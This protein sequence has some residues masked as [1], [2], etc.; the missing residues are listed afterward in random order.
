MVS[1]EQ[2][3]HDKAGMAL[4]STGMRQGIM[5]E[6][7]RQTKLASGGQWLNSSFHGT[8]E[9]WQEISS[10]L[11]RDARSARGHQTVEA[12]EYVQLI[13]YSVN[14]VIQIICRT[15]TWNVQKCYESKPH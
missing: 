8:D 5:W 6:A 2:T 14:R 11:A 9:E 13:T 4:C 3:K 7:H 10:A 15:L 1:Q 12:S